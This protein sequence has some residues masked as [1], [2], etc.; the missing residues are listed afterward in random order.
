[1]HLLP[2]LISRLLL[3]VV[4]TAALTATANTQTLTPV[5]QVDGLPMPESV[6]FDPAR[7]QYYVSN[8]N[9]AP[10]EEDH[11]GS[12]SLIKNNGQDVKQEWITGLSSPK[13]LEIDGD[14]LYVA[15]VKELVVVNVMH[16]KIVARY[17]APQA[18]VLNGIAIKEGVVYVSDRV[19]NAVYQLQDQPLSLWV[20]GTEL[21]SPNGLF[22]K[23]DHLYVGAW[24]NNIGADFST[25]T[26]GGLKRIHLETKKLETLTD[27]TTWM[28]LDGLHIANNNQD[29]LTT[30]FMKGQLL[31]I[32]AK[33]NI[34][35]IYEL[36]MSSADF[37]YNQKDGLL[38]VPYLMNGKVVAYK[39][40]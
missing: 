9:Q 25:Q 23:D 29:W 26:S 38:V 22:I 36:G 1:M 13:G 2:A 33:A 6:V 21:E 15:D 10:L 3:T 4:S 40:R 19:G 5:W 32:D 17:P 11:N 31:V 27:G 37:F 39:F 7:N 35:E 8:V 14:L 28:N 16:A 24:G 30:D 18:T 34:K 20:E 12:L